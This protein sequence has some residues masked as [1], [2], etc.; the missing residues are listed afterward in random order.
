LPDALVAIFVKLIEGD[1]LRAADGVV[2]RDGNGDQADFLGGSTRCI[3][4]S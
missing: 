2:N 3:E 1:F 4:L